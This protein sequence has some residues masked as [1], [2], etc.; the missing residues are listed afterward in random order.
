MGKRVKEKLE[1][2][3][4]YKVQGNVS[5]KEPE[6][7]SRSYRVKEFF[8]APDKIR[9]EIFDGKDKEKG[10]IFISK[11]G[12]VE[13][14]NP[15]IEEVYYLPVGVSLY[16][17]FSFLF[18]EKLEYMDL[19]DYKLEKEGDRYK[20]SFQDDI[21]TRQLVLTEENGLFNKDLMLEEINLFRKEE[22][23]EPYLTFSIEEIKWD[24]SLDS[25]VFDLEEK[26]REE[27][28]VEKDS[29]GACE[30]QKFTS[31]KLENLNFDVKTIDYPGYQIRHIGACGD[32]QQVSISYT[33][34]HG[35]ISFTQEKVEENNKKAPDF[36]AT[37]YENVLMWQ[38]E[39]IKYSLTGNYSREKLMELSARTRKL[40][41]ERLRDS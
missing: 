26:P 9:L 40:E 4:S 41:I 25:K 38:E 22:L 24:L 19:N 21:M 30:I 31:E 3:E 1:Q 11:A 29:A 20:L 32:R 8:K 10:Q 37:D 17:K 33:G 7:S 5:I 14:Y 6:G 34:A 13:I 27:K 35:N 15:I 2:I 28:M 12:E 16:N 39:N 36:I 23:I 18:Y